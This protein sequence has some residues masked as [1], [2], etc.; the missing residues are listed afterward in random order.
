M[1]TYQGPHASVTQ[2]FATS[3]A[4][5]A[6]EDLPPTIVA[7]AFDVFSKE[8]IGSHCGIID[9][10]IAWA[11][12][13]GV[14]VDKVV[15]DKDVIDQRAYD[16]YP[17]TLFAD[18]EF[19]S[20]DLELLAA[21]IGV[22]GPTIL[23]DK[24]YSVPNIEKTAGLSQAIIPF[25]DKTVATITSGT[26][27]GTTASHLI[28]AGVDFPTL[29][30]VAGDRVHNTTD[31]TSA[32]VTVVADGDLTIDN[33]IMVSGE[34][35]TVAKP[36]KIIATDLDTIVIPNGSVVTAQLKPGQSVFLYGTNV[37]DTDTW[38]TAG[39]IGSIG[40]DETKINLATS[41]TGAITAGRIVAG[42][43]SSA[44]TEVDNPNTLFDASADFIANKVKVGDLL[45]Y[46][47][48]ALSGTV[49]SPEVASITSIIDKNTIK[50][51]TENLNAAANGHIDSDFLKY[52][53]TNVTPGATV[54]VYSYDIKRLIGFSENY[55]LKDYNSGAGV[56]VTKISASQFTIADTVD[57]VAVPAPT[58]ND[59]FAITDAVVPAT[60]EGRAAFTYMR[61]YRIQTVFYDVGN[62]RYVI[63]TDETI[64][65]SNNTESPLVEYTTGFMESWNPKIETD[66]LGD[67]RAIRTEEEGVVKRITSTEDIFT[68]FVRTD[69]ESIDPRNELAFMMNIALQLSGGKVCYG[70][71]VDASA[72]NLSSEYGDAFEELKLYDVYSHAVGTTDSGVNGILAAYCTGQA[73]PYEGHER[74]ANA[75]YDQEDVFLQG[76]DTGSNTAVGLITVNGAINLITAG[77][78]VGDTVDIYTSA[79]VFV[80]QV[81]VTET[82]TASTQAQTDGAT[83]HAAGH[84]YK[85]RSGRKDDQAIKIGALGIGERRVTVVWPGWFSAYYGDESLTVPPYF[86]TAALTGMDSSFIAS[87]SFTNM[88]F[89]IPGLSNIQLDTSTNYRKLQL[90]EMA[91]GGIDVMIQDASISQS[92]KSRHDLTSDMSA[93][94]LRERSITKQ[95]DVVAKTIRNAVAP[96][97]GRYN[98]GSDLFKFLGQVC[99]IAATKLKSDGVIESLKI[100]SITRDAVIDDKIN[101]HLTARAFIAGN[102]YDITLLIVTR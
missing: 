35:Y 51:N 6:I 14:A 48:L 50:F 38:I 29:G 84:I 25:Y 55:M 42:A 71:N 72:A 61:L 28:D 20:V 97:V 57:S 24:D 45:Y 47:S 8:S 98:I 58:V 44:A 87:Q 81:T 101:I 26:T 18:S 74:T 91:A 17:P 49:A 80:E 4:A 1:T 99:S 75:C 12:A 90:D 79:N 33:D 56:P 64:N 62:S 32:L 23:L 15:Y 102:Y 67:F 77:V 65:D 19:G 27:D 34:T 94:Q 30:V 22:D 60:T 63:T 21:N 2:Q 39:T 86:I 13:D 100:D 88:P 73:E 70:V 53:Y 36:I 69:E 11:D 76:S 40:V 3:P 5:V 37:A 68:N 46:S 95:G 85:F 7:T 89:S 9:N 96:Y 31:D 92:I 66:V 16:F 83:L 10:E 54:Q 59:V 41:Y 52:K 82:P 93:V 43:V 78:T